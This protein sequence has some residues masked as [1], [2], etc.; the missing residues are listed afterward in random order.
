M[1]TFIRIRDQKV[2]S[3]FSTVEGFITVRAADGEEDIVSWVKDAFGHSLYASVKS[4]TMYK[5][6]IPHQ[7]LSLTTLESQYQ[8]CQTEIFGGYGDEEVEVPTSQ[9]EHTFVRQEDQ[10]VFEILPPNSIPLST[11]GSYRQVKS[12][13]GERDYI[14]W[15]A[16]MSGTVIFESILNRQRTYH[17]QL[18]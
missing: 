1:E 10:K 2:F 6:V 9:P 18:A 14:R 13:D 3:V 17:A 5:D 15:I 12:K 7:A 4:G 11:V 8:D 16:V